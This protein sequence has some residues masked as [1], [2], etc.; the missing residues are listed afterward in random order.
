M[1]KQ[2]AS[3]EDNAI[4][5]VQTPCPFCGSSKVKT[6]GEKV[7]ASS[8]WRCETCGQMWNAGRLQSSS[9][10]RHGGR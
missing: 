5:L 10:S 2:L 3:E 8:Y 6:P 7:D 9:R 1:S 4:Q